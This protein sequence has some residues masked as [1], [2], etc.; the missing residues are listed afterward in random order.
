MLESATGQ[1]QTKRVLLIRHAE[2][3]GAVGRCIGWSNLSLSRKGR[4]QAQL[5]A[6]R[7][8]TAAPDSIWSSNLSRTRDSATPLASRFR[9]P[10]QI[11]P[12]LRELDFGAWDGRLWSEIHER[13]GTRLQRWSDDFVER[14]T[15]RGE[16]FARLAERACAW[17][18]QMLQS[19]QT[20]I[21]CFTHAGVIRALDCFARGAPLKSAFELQLDYLAAVEI[22][23]QNERFKVSYAPSLLAPENTGDAIQ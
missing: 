11:D 1:S 22:S 15:P 12:R 21:V 9:I 18:E 4:E 2:P 7:W 8:S 14:E 3:E 6:A 5:L 23:Y 16:S 13:D 20:Q 17:L 10:L 19:S